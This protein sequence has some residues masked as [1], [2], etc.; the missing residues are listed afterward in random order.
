MIPSVTL[1]VIGY[2]LL[3]IIRSLKEERIDIEKGQKERE[4]DGAGKKSDGAEEHQPAEHRKQDDVRMHLKAFLEQ[5]RTQNIVDG[6]DSHAKDKEPDRGSHTAGHEKI[7]HSGNE[8][9]RHPDCGNKGGNGGNCT[10]QHGTWNPEK[11]KADGREDALYEH[12]EELALH[13]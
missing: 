13:Y 5:H 3:V 8:Y 7:D 1:L 10:P 6:A 11:P 9:D 4:R 2:W 12:D